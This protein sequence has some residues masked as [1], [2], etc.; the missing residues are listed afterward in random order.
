MKSRDIFRRPLAATRRGGHGT[1]ATSIF[2]RNIKPNDHGHSREENDCHSREE[3]EES[4]FVVSVQP[5]PWP[6]HQTA[7]SATADSDDRERRLDRSAPLPSGTASGSDECQG[8]PQT[9]FHRVTTPSYYK[10]EL[11]HGPGDD[12]GSTKESSSNGSGMVQLTSGDDNSVQLTPDHN[13]RLQLAS[14]SNVARRQA[15]II[16][17]S[18]I[19]ELESVEVETDDSDEKRWTISDSGKIKVAAMPPALGSAC[20]TISGEKDP[21]APPLLVGG[22]DGRECLVSPFPPAAKK[23]EAVDLSVPP[24]L[25][26]ANSSHSSASQSS[27]EE[28]AEEVQRLLDSPCMSLESPP[29]MTRSFLSPSRLFRDSV[30]GDGASAKDEEA[31]TSKGSGGDS[32]RGGRGPFDLL[33]LLLDAFSLN[34]GCCRQ[35]RCDLDEVNEANKVNEVTTTSENG[36]TYG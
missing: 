32:Q 24:M 15:L 11:V 25:V 34:G 16:R 12:G 29:R 2:R 35:C 4:L 6:P 5:G 3:D 10:I 36:I 27:D 31:A 9:P 20:P 8:T 22:N 23:G 19:V 26:K 17:A 21:G 7:L 28:T 14:H 1:A 18:P 33:G 13:K 30:S